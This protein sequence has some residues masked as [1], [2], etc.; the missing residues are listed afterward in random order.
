MGGGIN[1]VIPATPIERQVAVND[2]RHAPTTHEKML[3]LRRHL[4]LSDTTDDEDEEEQPRTFD[5]Q[6]MTNLPNEENLADTIQ[7]GLTSLLSKNKSIVLLKK[8]FCYD[9]YRMVESWKAAWHTRNEESTG[10]QFNHFM[11]NRIVEFGI[12][13]PDIPSKKEMAFYLRVGSRIAKYIPNFEPEIRKMPIS[14]LDSKYLS[15]PAF[16]ECMQD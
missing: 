12:N 11:W 14:F 10:R 3:A 4:A 2:R 15:D 6:P 8:I 1:G 16:H 5:L 13:N 9:V 7:S